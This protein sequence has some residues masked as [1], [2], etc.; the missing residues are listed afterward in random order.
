MKRK[1]HRKIY[2]PAYLCLLALFTLGVA[3]LLWTSREERLSG[4]ENRMLS[5]APELTMESVVSGEYMSGAEAWLT[6]GFPG[7]DAAVGLSRSLM[8]LFTYHGENEID[9]GMGDAQ[10]AEDA[11]PAFAE[12]EAEIVSQ[13]P[14]E[15]PEPVSDIAPNPET[16]TETA[17]PTNKGAGLYFVRADGEKIEKEKYSPQ[18]LQTIADNLNTYRDLL[19]EDGTVHMMYLPVSNLARYLT[20][21]G[22]YVAWE[23]D[24]AEVLQPLVKDGV[25]IYDAEEILMETIFDEYDY[26]TSDHHW[27]PLGASRFADRTLLRQGLIPNGYYEYL[28]RLESE[29]RSGNNYNRRQLM[30]LSPK[31]N[32]VQ[33]QVPTTPVQGWKLMH[34]TEKEERE[35]LLEVNPGGYANYYLYLRGMLG[36]WRTYATGYHTGRDALIIGDSYMTAFLPY[37]TPYYDN[38][39][40]ADFRDGRYEPWEA[41]GTISQYMETYGTDDVY[42]LTC[43]WT[44]LDGTFLT[45]RIIDYLN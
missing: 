24:L 31:Q 44:P 7:R 41:G 4:T 13:V 1:K 37:L 19:G 26:L 9:G 11:A 33:V 23:S 14:A 22:Q 30:D 10:L 42:F 39:T 6:D 25:Y 18:L 5:A 17:P 20:P 8:G 35:Y 28:Y 43:T 12:E 27:T 32:D 29:Y 45:R 21:G 36:G 2:L 16:D 15:T 3:E 34:I 38:I 40:I